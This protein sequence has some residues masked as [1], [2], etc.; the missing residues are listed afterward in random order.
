MHFP[1]DSPERTGNILQI[2]LQINKWHILDFKL[3][4]CSEYCIRSFGWFPSVWILCANLSEHSVNSTF[5]E[6]NLQRFRNVCT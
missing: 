3:L 5:I 2:L 1:E 4:L 6:W